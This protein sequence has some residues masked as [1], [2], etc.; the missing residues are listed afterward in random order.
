MQ[1]V[2]I[3]RERDAFSPWWLCNRPG[4][5]LQQGRSGWRLAANVTSPPA[6]MITTHTYR[7]SADFIFHC[8]A[9]CH[10]SHFCSFSLTRRWRGGARPPQPPQGSFK[11][12]LRINVLRDLLSFVFYDEKTANKRSLLDFQSKFSCYRSE[13]IWRAILLLS[14]RSWFF[15]SALVGNKRFSS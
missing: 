1:C 11:W 4:A 7:E 6:K 8:A 3:C 15:V 9:L 2:F 5:R 12:S 14:G 13:Y 10:F